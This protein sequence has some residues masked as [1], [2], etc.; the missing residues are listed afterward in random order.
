[1]SLLSILYGTKKVVIN[2]SSG[3]GGSGFKGIISSIKRNVLQEVGVYGGIVLD[4]TTI[5][6]HSYKAEVTENPIEDGEPVADHVNL[7]PVILKIEG[8]VSDSPLGFALIGSALNAV[9][10]FS[11][12]FGTQSRAKDAFD[13]I[14]TLR[15]NRIPFTVITNLKRYENMVVSDVS[16]PFTSDTGH[17]LDLKLELTQVSIVKSKFGGGNP[18]SSFLG[19]ASS[20]KNLGNKVTEAVP[21]SSSVVDAAASVSEDNDGLIHKALFPK[22]DITINNSSLGNW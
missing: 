12:L 2:D 17:A 4:C 8:L 13:A 22:K 3:S 16:F 14:V 20:L 7:K 11:S 6:D 9:Q 15:N 21:A 10:R 19:K 1:M 18:L 5:E